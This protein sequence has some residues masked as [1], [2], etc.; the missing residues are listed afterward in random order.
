MRSRQ[1]NEFSQK[2]NRKKIELV[3][4]PAGHQDLIVNGTLVCLICCKSYKKNGNIIYHVLTHT[5]EKPYQCDQCPKS[6][7]TSSQLNLH[8]KMHNGE[9]AFNCKYCTKS[10]YLNSHLLDHERIH[11]GEKPFQVWPLDPIQGGRLMCC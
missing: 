10:F 2:G 7:T 6:F 8:I 4:R 11:T 1:I 9:K 5:G 3:A